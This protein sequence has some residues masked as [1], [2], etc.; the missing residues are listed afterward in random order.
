MNAIAKSSDAVDTDRG[1]YWNMSTTLLS[2]QPATPGTKPQKEPKWWSRV[3]EHVETRLQA[4]RV[5][6]YSWWIHW[7][8]IATYLLPTRYVW[9][10][11]PNKTWRGQQL[12]TA[13]MNGTAT[14][15]MQ[16]CAGGLWSG[17][18]N[19]SR[20]W[21]VFGPDMQHADL[22]A[23]AK[24]WFAAVTHRMEAVLQGSNFYNQTA[25]MFR[26]EVGFGTSPMIGYEDAEDMVRFYLPCAGEYYLGAS[27]RLADNVFYREYT[28]NVSEIVEM[29]KLENCPPEVAKM[30]QEGGG[31]LQTE[32]VVAHAI[33]PN[34]SLASR[35][36][37]GD[38]YAVSPRFPWREIYWIRGSKSKQPLSACGFHERPFAVAR[39]AT[40]SNDAYGRGPGMDALGDIKQLQLMTIRQAEAV[41]KIARPP[42]GADVR[43][44]NEPSSIRAGDI[45]YMDTVNGKG[46]FWPL[47]EVHPDVPEKLST[48]IEKIETRIKDTFFVNIFMAISQMQ[49]VQPRNELEL[50]Q[51]DLERLQV[52]G[53]MIHLFET[54]FA[55]PILNRVYAI[56][57]RRGL[58]PP[59]PESLRNMPVKVTYISIL[60]L[61][62]RASQSVSLTQAL[63]IGAGLSSA[64]KAAA[65][66]DPLRIIDLDEAM[67]EILEMANVDPRIV[68]SKSQVQ[69]ADQMRAQQAQQAQLA[70]ITPQAVEAA[71]NL[72]ATPMGGD[73]ALSALLGASSR[74]GGPV[75]VG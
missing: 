5:W 30:W 62:L 29:F 75:G 18:T 21:F 73:T 61:A 24:Q 25:Q 10:V 35:M 26:D 72:A 43:L 1:A 37:E 15:A 41:D 47:F 48:V 2:E 23:D 14:L 63:K 4:L 55:S 44:K 60:H 50:T 56:M 53:P 8:Q 71:K 32:L 39:W 70:A 17:L 33:E 69:K 40:V 27:A 36:G 54:E 57:E 59:K 20:P 6:R 68:F 74:V 13:I 52:L 28:L 65:L 9:L 11:T 16:V 12:N 45:T 34:T 66:A 38:F 22:D 67:R 19:P 31:A 49:G 7:G 46:A 58:I 51:R 42:M 3:Y 64:A